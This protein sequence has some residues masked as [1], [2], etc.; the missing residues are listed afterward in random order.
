MI[1][2]HL[3]RINT[4]ITR[5]YHSWPVWELI[6][7]NK[8]KHNY[9]WLVTSYCNETGFP[10][11]PVDTIVLGVS[12]VQVPRNNDF[13]PEVPEIQNRTLT[14][15]KEIL[16]FNKQTNYPNQIAFRLKKTSASFNILCIMSISKIR[17]V[18]CNS[19]KHHKCTYPSWGSIVRKFTCWRFVY[20]VSVVSE[21]TE[22]DII[23]VCP[24]IHPRREEIPS[25]IKSV[26]KK[27]FRMIIITVLRHFSFW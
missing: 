9:L 17:M 20:I 10:K 3:F 19:Q 8:L 18:V 14:I 7:T 22:K 4:I 6:L 24:S 11:L 15:M 13:D 25:K 2:F 27:F 21:L 23:L 16:L 1:C 12:L 5:S 26:M